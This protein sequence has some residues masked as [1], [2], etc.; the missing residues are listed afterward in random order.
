MNE[1]NADAKNIITEANQVLVDVQYD[2]QH[3]VLTGEPA[4]KR[5]AEAKQDI[6]DANQSLVTLQQGPLVESLVAIRLDIHELK[7]LITVSNDHRRL[8]VF[9]SERTHARLDK[10]ESQIYGIL[11]QLDR[12]ER[13]P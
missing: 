3:K 5:A 13:G 1:Q 10:I 11:Q 4:V 12:A 9:D 2:Q 7:A 6:T 8:S